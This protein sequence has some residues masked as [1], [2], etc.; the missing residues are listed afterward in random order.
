MT[1]VTFALG[2]GVGTV[3]RRGD[4]LEVFYPK[5]LLHPAADT[6][7]E[8]AHALGYSGHGNVA[9][10]LGAK[11]LAA[12][13]ALGGEHTPLAESAKPVVATFLAT[14][15]PLASV[16]EAYLKL[17]LLSHRLVKP[18]GLDLTGL[19]KVLP[20]VAWTSRGAIDPEELGDARLR[21]RLAGETLSV[22]MVDKF[23]KMTDY[24]VPA[25]VR[26]ADATR[27][28]LGAYVG[29]GTTVMQEGFINFNAGCEGP[30][31]VEGRVSA[32]VWV[33][34]HSDIGGGAS[35][36]GTLSGGGNV[37]ISLGQRCLLGANA[38]L[39]IPLGDDCI[40]E[41]GL[42]V[43]AASKLRLLGKSGETRGTI[44]AS[45]LAGRSG[46]LIRRNS[47]DGAI[48]CLPNKKAVALNPDLHGHN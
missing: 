5:P 1:E 41:A 12:L 13:R 47:L 33:G 7:R 24:V 9:I 29:E 26:I 42:Y 20:N 43:T 36:M 21:C 17:H 39:G 19:F 18:N 34:A 10:R 2:I 32:G 6:V 37:R 45:E 8:L 31:M 15:A 40:V 25:G 44:K 28:R 38:G 48:E 30:A 22:D 3:N 16:P 14:D 35:T 23:P 11:E 4:W 46:L 27:V